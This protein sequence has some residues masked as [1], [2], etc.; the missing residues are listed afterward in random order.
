MAEQ[1]ICKPGVVPNLAAG[2]TS[3]NP[4]QFLKA[5]NVVKASLQ[6]AIS[7]RNNA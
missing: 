2:I 4:F 3:Q 7:L 5:L 1:Q 6:K